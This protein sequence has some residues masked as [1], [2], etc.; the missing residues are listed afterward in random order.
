MT[1][2]VYCRLGPLG[3]FST[4]SLSSNSFD[5]TKPKT[6]LL[7]VSSTFISIILSLYVYQNSILSQVFVF[8]SN[9]RYPTVLQHLPTII[10]LIFFISF[11]FFY[12]LLLYD[13]FF[14][15]LFNIKNRPFFGIKFG[16]LAPTPRSVI[17]VNNNNDDGLHCRLLRSTYF[18]NNG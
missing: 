7:P 6:C 8:S 15:V 16:G 10:P 9:L 18:E 11:F 4:R 13:S 12:I 3:Q 2:M 5:V 17:Y 14:S 1:S